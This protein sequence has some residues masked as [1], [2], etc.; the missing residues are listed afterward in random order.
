MAAL[1][2]GLLILLARS[3][4]GPS[5]G[6]VSRQALESPS[7][8]QPN[9]AIGDGAA[10]LDIRQ[11]PADLS[12]PKLVDGPPQAGQ[13]A[14]EFLPAY[15]DTE[16]YHVTYLPTDWKPGHRYPVIVEYAGNGSYQ[17]AYG[18]ISTGIVEDSKLGYGISG[19]KAFIWVCLPYLNNAGNRPMIQWWGDPPD[20]DPR[21]TVKYCQQ[22][23]AETC[24]RYGGDPDRVF[25]AGF[26]RGAIA[27]NFIGLHDDDIAQ[28]WRGFIPFSHY[29]GV[30]DFGLPG[31]ERDAALRRIRRLGDRPQ[32]ICSEPGPRNHSVET[33]R[34]YLESAGV[35]QNLTFRSTGFRNHNDAWVL[36]PSKAREELRA[37]IDYLLE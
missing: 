25:L 35:T 9:P 4:V 27:C 17:N 36:R 32:F 16:V 37:W 33:T 13:R 18:D 2:L 20:F 28:L 31:L 30:S 26:S 3:S 23:V 19:G 12:V 34:R 1:F 6:E 14:K 10:L 21:P 5:T 24:R 22:A 29:D 8:P 15:A 11:V 7:A